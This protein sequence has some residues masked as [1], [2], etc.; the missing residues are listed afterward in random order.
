MQKPCS[1]TT[2]ARL[3][4]ALF[5]YRHQSPDIILSHNRLAPYTQNPWTIATNTLLLA[6]HENS[7]H[8]EIFFHLTTLL[9]M[10]LAFSYWFF[11]HFFSAFILF[12]LLDGSYIIYS[13]NKCFT[14]SPLSHLFPY[15]CIK[16]Y[17]QLGCDYLTMSVCDHSGLIYTMYD[18]QHA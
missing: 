1:D 7:N 8:P 14:I 15:P 3:F 2:N 10:A 13:Y 4:S 5:L 17:L 9:F 11:L 18:T 6:V 16:S 12:N